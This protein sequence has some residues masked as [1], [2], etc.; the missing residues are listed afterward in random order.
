M[1]LRNAFNQPSPYRRGVA[2]IL[3]AS[4]APWV[5]NGVS[6]FWTMPAG[7]LDVTPFA[8]AL[9]SV[10]VLLATSRLRL[11]SLFP[12]LL[13]VARVQ[14][15]EK[16]ADAVMVLDLDGRVVT[17]NPAAGRLSTRGYPISPAYPSRRS[18][19]SKTP[20]QAE[21]T[22][23]A[24]CSSG[25]LWAKGDSKRYFDVVS[26]PLG[27]GSGYGMG[28]LLVLRDI[29]ERRR[30]EEAEAVARESLRARVVELNALC[31]IAETVAG[32]GDLNEALM[33][34]AEQV[35]EA[36]EARAAAVVTFGEDAE[37][38]LVVSRTTEGERSPKTSCSRARLVFEA[39]AE[40]AEGGA[41]VIMNDLGPGALP[42]PSGRAGNWGCRTCSRCRSYCT[43]RPSARWPWSAGRAQT[44]SAS[45]TRGSCSRRR[46]QWPLPSSTPACARK[47][48]R[49]PP[50]SCA[51]ILAR[52][53]H[54][55]VTQS[56][57]SANL[58]AQ[59]LPAV[60]E[61]DYAEGL[62]GLMQLQRLVRSALAELRILLYELRPGTLAGVSLDQLLEKLGDSMAG[63]ANVNVD[64][65]TRLEYELPVGVKTALYRIA[66]EAFN[67][68]AK[69]SQAERVWATA[70]SDAQGVTL[71][72]EDD[73]IGVDLDSIAGGHMGLG[74][75][76]ER[77]EEIGAEFDIQRIDPTGT[78]VTV[79]WTRP[80]APVSVADSPPVERVV[81]HQ[82]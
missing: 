3:V 13:R 72:I 82:R 56:V 47:R 18:W 48:T 73:G 40:L 46:A 61:R 15:L 39:L 74:I 16:M 2:V 38:Q 37:T 5:G 62:A 50:A 11:F 52:E 53:L 29:T 24:I 57:Y 10:V 60:L 30:A 6:L 81:Q 44:P 33:T 21:A 27:L 76:R 55:A 63:Q 12:A 1:L 64:I 59:A 14:V 7:G 78:Q 35:A 42:G 58:T 41:P 80:G 34:A 67:N 25:S 65:N 8:F 28:R 75:M 31:R 20:C 79:R 22:W 51:S 68:I 32:P 71:D 70:V 17:S 23:K 43:R 36:L 49:R 54:D 45:A 19:G 77:A 69:H 9:T 66:Q 26:S 4:L